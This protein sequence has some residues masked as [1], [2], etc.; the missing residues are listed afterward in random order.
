M[1]RKYAKIL[2]ILKAII[3]IFHTCVAGSTITSCVIDCLFFPR[4]HH[5]HCRS[6]RRR[7]RRHRWAEGSKMCNQNSVKMIENGMAWEVN[8]ENISWEIVRN[9]VSKEVEKALATLNVT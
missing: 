7:R 4:H 1:L 6:C 2:I 8:V 5:H 9:G 3:I